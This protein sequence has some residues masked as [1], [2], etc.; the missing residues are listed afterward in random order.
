MSG[1]DNFFILY[2]SVFV[3]FSVNKVQPARPDIEGFRGS[4]A[5][6]SCIAKILS[7][8]QKYMRAQ[9]VRGNSS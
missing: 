1:K 2:L 8:S 4:E 6:A 7:A 9:K 5:Q 3:L